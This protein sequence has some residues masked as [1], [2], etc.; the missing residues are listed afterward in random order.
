MSSRTSRLIGFLL[1]WQ[2]LGVS[3]SL[4]ADEKN[5]I[6]ATMSKANALRKAADFPGALKA[7][8]DAMAKCETV[9]PADSIYIPRIWNDTALLHRAMGQLEKAEKLHRQ[10]LTRREK[11]LGANHPDIAQSLLNLAVVLDDEGRYH[12]SQV[13]LERALKIFEAKFGSNDP[14]VASCLSNLGIL[15]YY[16]GEYAQAEALFIRCLQINERAGE[17]YVL[18]VAENLNNLANVYKNLSQ[19]KEAEK[20]FE[21]SLAIYRKELGQGHLAIAAQLNNLGNLYKDQYQ[22]EKAEPLLREALKLREDKLG[23]NHTDTALSLNSLGGLYHNQTKYAAA[24]PLY[25]RSIQIYEKIDPQHPDLAFV[26]NNL[27]LTKG[28]LSKDQ[29]ALHLNQRALKIR[30]AK[31]GQDH[32]NVAVILHHLAMT[33]EK[34]GNTT[35]AAATIDR[36]RRIIRRHVATILPML[37]EE[38][39]LQFLIN[40]DEVPFFKA[41]TLAYRH[42]DDAKLREMSFGWVLNGKAVSQESLAERALL[43]RNL[44][45][46]KYAAQAKELL[47]LRADLAGLK[48]SLPKKGQEEAQATSDC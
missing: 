25:E 44:E 8:E 38:E 43:L 27:A 42:A 13:L 26:L 31:Y 9:F 46:P 48:L 41:L 22:Y 6:F 23:N 28:Y 19:F 21:L 3:S 1:L 17:K 14:Q 47:G 35:T 7:Y 29:D 39:Q 45:D 30:E 33:E 4:I 16:R 20:F 18:S 15:N 2:F 32:P 10:A 36:S 40:N 37:G 5:E 34:L 11:Y 24:E 12:E